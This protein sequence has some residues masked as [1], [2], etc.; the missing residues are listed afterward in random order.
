M[1]QSNVVIVERVQRR[2]PHGGRG[3]KLIDVFAL[4]GDD[5]RPPHGGRGLKRLACI[6]SIAQ[7]EVA[8][9]TGGVD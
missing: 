5:R 9:H 3:L 2:P 1:K 7:R 8:P 4:L 6:R